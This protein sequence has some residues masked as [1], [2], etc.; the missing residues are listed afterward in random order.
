MLRDLRS[1]NETGRNPVGSFH[2]RHCPNVSFFNG[3][4]YQRS[5]NRKADRESNP[6][7][8]ISSKALLA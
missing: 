1:L 5:G 3:A 7:E 8:E 6:K 2:V 4:G